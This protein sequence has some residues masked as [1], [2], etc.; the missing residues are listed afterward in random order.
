MKMSLPEIAK[1]PL[2]TKFGTFDLYDFAWSKNE[3]D[4]VLA[5]VA[6][7][8]DRIPHVRVQSACYTGEIFESTDCD[9]HWQLETGLRRIQEEGGIF[10]YML[11]DGRGA[12]LLTKIRGMNI[13]ATQ[14]LDTADA[15]KAL[16]SPL[17]PREYERAGFILKHFGVTQCRLLTNNP[18]KIS[19]LEAQGLVV[20]RIAHMSKPTPANEAYLRSKAMKL[21]HLMK[22][23]GTDG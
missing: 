2:N 23:F 17:D 12:G 13:T 21:G 6:D 19:G 9:C 10:I 1:S 11:C 16:G 22:P 7:Y 3:Q 8:G 5:L 18:R 14:G 15:Y 4:N 20:Q